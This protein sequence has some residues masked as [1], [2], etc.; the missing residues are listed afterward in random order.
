MKDEG[1]RAPW[2]AKNSDFFHLLYRKKWNS[3]FL[4]RKLEISSTGREISNRI[5]RHASK[6]SVLMHPNFYNEAPYFLSSYSRFL[7]RAQRSEFIA[8]K[9]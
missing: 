8:L 2:S 6:L 7:D 5:F 3:L 9:V 4:I 1:V